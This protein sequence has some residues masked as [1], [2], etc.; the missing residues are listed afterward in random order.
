MAAL[1]R[2]V[3]SLGEPATLAVAVSVGWLVAQIVLL[4]VGMPNTR[5]RRSE[6]A[7]VLCAF[8]FDTVALED[9]HI[10]IPGFSALLA[11]DRSGREL[12][13]KIMSREAW[14]SQ[15]PLRTWRWI[16]FR[17]V[18]DDHPFAAMRRPV[19]REAL[20]ALKAYADGVPTAR[21]AVSTSIGVDSKLLAFDSFEAHPLSMFAD[22]EWTPEILAEIWRSVGEL[23]A[24]RTAHHRLSADHLILDGSGRVRIVEFSSAEL[25]AP[26]RV[27]AVDVAE[28]LAVTAAHV[29]SEAT[30]AAAV[31]ELGAPA[32]AAALPR[33]Q[34]LA[35]TDSTRALVKRTGCLDQLAAEVRRVTGATDVPLE[36]LQR[37]RPNTLVAIVMTAVAVWA[38]VPQLLGAGDVWGLISRANWGW[39]L[40]AVLL[41]A[42]TYVAA[43]LA[44]AGSLPDPVPL[45]PNVEVQ[46]A[47][48]FVA[49]AATAAS[50]ALT[51]RFLQKRGIDLAG[52]IAAVGVN[53]VAGVVVHLSL[54]GVFIGFGGTK[55]LDQFEL[56][57][58]SLF[59][60][61]MAV[62]VVV[63]GVALLIPVVRRVARQ[64]VVPPVQRSW[65]GLS[66][67]A[68]NPTKLAELFGGSAGITLGYILALAASAQ[69]FGSELSI[70]TIA[71]VYLI[72]SVV[73][74]AAPT[75]GGIGAVE[76]TL[77]AGFTSA[78]MRA[79]VA[80][81]SVMLF[82]VATFWLPLVPGWFS[83][84]RLQHEGAI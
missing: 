51:A 71:L 80:F 49:V 66:D 50:M 2:I 78:G 67:I 12:F 24:S 34:P 43:A 1:L 61:I 5:P 10:E 76:A 63:I 56:P 23:R 26:E 33:L 3:T 8:G 48:S 30:V 28:V 6:V 14:T 41:S 47:T 45:G 36:N 70:I 38:L 75:P 20:G 52:A 11:I 40:M 74:S 9:L 27:L 16:R 7:S 65:R 84:E 73:S 4:V 59:G 82:R 21:L 32:V 60:L 55:I 62:V 37:V 83:Y 39:A 15:L 44:F 46:L 29:G 77:I 13:V 54:L 53:T 69:A 18:G 25:G 68:R 31:A 64:H 35:L 42:F 22:D 57:S 58:M 17:G 19:D 79:D 72:G 81:G